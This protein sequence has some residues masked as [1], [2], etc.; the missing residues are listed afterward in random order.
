KKGWLLVEEYLK[1]FASPANHLSNGVGYIEKFY[2]SARKYIVPAKVNIKL[3]S[4]G[5]SA[6]IPFGLSE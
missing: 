6:W 5:Y 1:D 2:I 4:I 3:E